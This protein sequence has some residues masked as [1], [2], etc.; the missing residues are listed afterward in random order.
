MSHRK[1]I[2]SKCHIVIKWDWSC[3]YA[4]S[5]YAFSQCKKSTCV[6]IDVLPWMIILRLFQTE[7][8]LIWILKHSVFQM[9]SARVVS[10]CSSDPAVG[11]LF[12]DSHNPI[13]ELKRI[14][15]MGTNIKDFSFYYQIACLCCASY[16]L[17][18]GAPFD[19]RKHHSVAACSNWGTENNN[20]YC[21]N[22]KVIIMY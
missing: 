20:K 3:W 12:E 1:D 6:F 14:L 21:L 10:Q 15:P 2:S 22:A 5:L 11:A 19:W 7:S 17:S 16:P 18:W 8:W 13:A 9:Y 4:T